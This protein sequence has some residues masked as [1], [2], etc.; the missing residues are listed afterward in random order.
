MIIEIRLKQLIVVDK[1]IG[2]GQC[3]P[4]VGFLIE[5]RHVRIFSRPQMCNTKVLATIVITRLC[6]VRFR[7][8]ELLQIIRIVRLLSIQ[9]T[10]Y[11]CTQ[12]KLSYFQVLQ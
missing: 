4:L 1:S 9:I 8:V 3:E 11:Q 5:K 12:P 6:R 10:D 7:M 2:K